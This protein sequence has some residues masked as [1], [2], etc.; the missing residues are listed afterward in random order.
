[1]K[2]KGCPVGTVKHLV[3]GK[4]VKDKLVIIGADWCK[5]CKELKKV[6]EHHKIP[7]IYRKV[8]VNK[9]AKEGMILPIIKF[10]DG[11]QI[12]GFSDIETLKEIK[13]M[14]KKKK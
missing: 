1:M 12:I 4:C 10:P 8:S 3:S 9:V 5:P 11:R 2:K 14:R 7:H 13:K 6:L